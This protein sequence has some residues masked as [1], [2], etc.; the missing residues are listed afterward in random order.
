MMQKIKKAV[1]PDA[2][3][4]AI[5]VDV[6]AHMLDFVVKSTCTCSNYSP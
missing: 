5:A 3:E 2:I 4:E 1:F 6:T